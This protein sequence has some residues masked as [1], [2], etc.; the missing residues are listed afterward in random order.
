MKALLLREFHGNRWIA[1]SCLVTIIIVSAL[2]PL[3]LALEFWNAPGG[4]T[5]ELFKLHPHMTIIPPLLYW[6]IFW[7]I[8]SA[9][10]AAWTDKSLRIKIVLWAAFSLVVATYVTFQE[11]TSSPLMLFELRP[12]QGNESTWSTLYEN[13][14]SMIKAFSSQ[15]VPDEATPTQLEMAKSLSYEYWHPKQR[16]SISRGFYVATFFLSTFAM[17][18]TFFAIS[19]LP[20]GDRETQ[21]RYL[22][23]LV[24]AFFCYAL[25]FPARFYY[26]LEIKSVLVGPLERLP[27]RDILLYLTGAVFLLFVCIRL[28]AQIDAARKVTGLVV[29]FLLPLSSRFATKFLGNVFGLTSNPLTWITMFC[30]FIYMFFA[31]R[32]LLPPLSRNESPRL[33]PKQKRAPKE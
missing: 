28:I 16:F 5:F 10:S 29:L 19:Y 15:A 21:S 25:W 3:C 32:S 33:L 31:F 14:R 8:G 12:D 20:E 13:A 27:G 7:M 1:L 23:L 2:Y 26:N 18:T 30:A 9:Q 6:A 24:G 17:L 4:R 22:Y 11:I